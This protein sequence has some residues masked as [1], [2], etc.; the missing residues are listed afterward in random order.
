M[1]KPSGP[2]PP[3]RR[4]AQETL[5]P[6]AAGSAR[7]RPGAGAGAGQPAG[8]ATADRA[9]QV[10]QA[11]AQ[12]PS[13]PPAAAQSAPQ[14]RMLQVAVILGGHGVKG[15][16]RL[17]VFIEDPLALGDLSPIVDANGKIWRLKPQT[18]AKGV[19]IAQ[20]GDLRYRDQVE[21]LKGLKLFVP[22]SALP[23]T[24]DDEFYP[25]ELEGLRALRPDGSLFGEVVNLRDYGAGDLLNVRLA[26]TGKQELFAFTK[27][28][29]PEVKVAEGYLVIDPPGEV[30]SR[31]EEGVH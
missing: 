25:H 17:K 19:L 5:K 24:D 20:V 28:V 8:K 12:I 29:V 18:F 14:E 26:E 7:P 10:T 3:R 27:A 6:R 23:Q 30:I 13:K 31:D 22:T 21:A 2:K 9:P 4:K 16:A 15:Q 11:A 1:T